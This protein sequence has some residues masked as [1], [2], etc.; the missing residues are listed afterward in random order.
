MQSRLFPWLA[1]VLS[2]VVVAACPPAKT[3]LQR[4]DDAAVI[5]GKTVGA[6]ADDVKGTLRQTMSSSSDEA[7]AASLERMAEA[8]PTWTSKAWSAAKATV[9]VARSE[10]VSLASDLI[11]EG[12]E[13]LEN[14]QSVSNTEVQA[15]AAQLT[16]LSAADPIVQSAVDTT[17]Y[18]LD[19]HR[20][21][22]LEYLKWVRATACFVDAIP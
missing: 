1:F 9:E 21:G 18:S 8:K 19:Y 2:T 16:G 11:C 6:G 13:R 14:Q 20:Q 7:F 4:I 22:D 12:L 17:M 3:A 5:V 15:W 10:P